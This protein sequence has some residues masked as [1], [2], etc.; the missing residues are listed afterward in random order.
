MTTPNSEIIQELRADKAALHRENETL[1]SQIIWNAGIDGMPEY[2]QGGPEHGTR[3]TAEEA[4][5]I[6]RQL[7]LLRALNAGYEKLFGELP[8]MLDQPPVATLSRRKAVQTAMLL[9]DMAR[10]G[11]EVL[12]ESSSSLCDGYCTIPRK[13]H[14]DLLAACQALWELPPVP[15][16][17]ESGG[18]DRAEFHLIRY[19]QP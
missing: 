1:R 15:S 13:V 12:V 17:V 6:H 16:P 9:L 18:T 7:E 11:Q 8:P 19:L 5:S 4:N 14:D 2:V 10:A 3:L